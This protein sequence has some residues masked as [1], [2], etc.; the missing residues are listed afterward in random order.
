MLQLNKTPWNMRKNQNQ[1]FQKNLNQ[2]C[3]ALLTI[4]SKKDIKNFLIDLCTVTELQAMSERLEVAKLISK[5][6]PYRKI[7]ETTGLST[8]TITRIANW[9]KDGK[10]G[11]NKVLKNLKS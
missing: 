2:L 1:N 7:S 11:Y 4:D 10:Q 3:Q 6:I 5:K 8:T 9:M